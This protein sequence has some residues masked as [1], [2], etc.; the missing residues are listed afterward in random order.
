MSE[1]VKKAK[2]TDREQDLLLFDYQIEDFSS[3]VVLSSAFFLSINYAK[4]L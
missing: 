3:V 1:Q 4:V 2:M